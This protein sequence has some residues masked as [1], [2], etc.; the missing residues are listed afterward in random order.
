MTRQFTR[1][2]L[3]QRIWMS[4]KRSSTGISNDSSRNSES[5]GNTNS[6]YLYTITV[7]LLITY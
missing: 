4:G 5:Y 2:S 1:I 7:Y 3:L 6:V